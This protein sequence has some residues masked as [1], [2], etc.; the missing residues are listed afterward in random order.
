MDALKEMYP[1]GSC[2]SFYSDNMAD[3]VIVEVFNNGVRYGKTFSIRKYGLLPACKMA[4]EF[5]DSVFRKLVQDG[6][7]FKGM[8]AKLPRYLIEEF[9]E[10]GILATKP[11]D[12]RFYVYFHKLDGEIVYIGSGT[13]NRVSHPRGR[14]KEHRDLLNKM[15][16]EI[17]ADGLTKQDALLLEKELVDKYKPHLNKIPVSIAK[18][19]KYSIISEFVYYDESSPTYIRNKT[20]NIYSRK[21]ADSVVGCLN[22]SSK[23]KVIGINSETYSLHRVIY[24]L[25]YKV[26]VPANMVIDHIDCDKTNNHPSNLRLVTQ[27]QNSTNRKTFTDSTGITFKDGYFT[28]TWSL[29]SKQYNKRLTCSKYFPD[30][31]PD[32]AK[33]KTYELALAYRKEKIEELKLLGQYLD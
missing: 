26:D 8:Y 14:T 32:E 1:L 12:N 4:V 30:L 2:I 17:A 25:Y 24:C 16:F 10:K 23:Y 18:D 21:P 9:Q 6:V 3:K 5:R 31:P 7:K 13:S 11:D 33:Q 15:V 22:S 19:V 28:V 20:A 27:Q 29:N